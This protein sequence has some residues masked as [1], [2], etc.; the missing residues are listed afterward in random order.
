MTGGKNIRRNVLYM[1][2]NFVVVRIE[3]PISPLSMV[4]CVLLFE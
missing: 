1:G 4:T 3:I 2:Y